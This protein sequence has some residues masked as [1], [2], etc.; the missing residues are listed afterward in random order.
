MGS[1]VIVPQ[2]TTRRHHPT[3]TAQR[4]GHRYS[5][6]RR[7]D[8]IPSIS[9]IEGPSIT[10]TTLMSTENRGENSFSG[11]PTSPSFGS[12]NRHLEFAGLSLSGVLD[13]GSGLTLSAP[14]DTSPKRQR[15]SAQV[16]AA[17]AGTPH[18]GDGLLCRHGSHGTART[19]NPSPEYVG[20]IPNSPAVSAATHGP[21]RTCGRPARRRDHAHPV[22]SRQCQTMAHFVANRCHALARP[23]AIVRAASVPE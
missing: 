2:R 3:T 10:L 20:T 4:R 7:S 5:E 9:S 1:S 22:S 11:P 12:D 6:N 21:E 15:G 23:G 17:E 16:I 19:V 13:D 8:G 14:S 18:L